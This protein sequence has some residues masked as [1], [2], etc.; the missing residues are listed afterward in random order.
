MRFLGR[1]CAAF[2]VFQQSMRQFMHE[3]GKLLRLGLAG[4]NGDS[5]AITHSKGRGDVLGKDK[6]DVLL[7][8]KRNET[9]AILS[10]LAAHL[11]HGG[12]LCALGLR[13]V[14]DVSIAKPNQNAGVL[15]GDMCSTMSVPMRP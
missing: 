9:G 13:H 1:G 15:L 8:D 7:V 11:P 6:L 4:E 5:A 10:D 12:K 14:K 2:G 3:G